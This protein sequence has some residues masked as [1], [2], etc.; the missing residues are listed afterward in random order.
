[1]HGVYYTFSP[2]AIAKKN[3]CLFEII[4]WYY[5]SRLLTFHYPFTTWIHRSTSWQ[6]SKIDNQILK[7]VLSTTIVNIDWWICIAIASKGTSIE[8][9]SLELGNFALKLT[10]EKLDI[11]EQFILIKVVTLPPNVRHID[12]ENNHITSHCVYEFKCICCY[13]QIGIIKCSL[14]TRV[15]ENVQ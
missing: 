3:P 13:N 10:F 6:V 5:E 15:T 11:M 7:V 14:R 8:H 12:S 1:M 4:S 2:C 9:R